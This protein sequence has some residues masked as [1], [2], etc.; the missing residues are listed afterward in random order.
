MSTFG[1]VSKIHRKCGNFHNRGNS[2]LNLTSE[3]TTIG[4][5]IVSKCTPSISKV[6]AKSVLG[7]SFQDPLK[8]H[9]KQ[10]NFHN[11]GGSQ[12][13]LTSEVTTIGAHIV[14]KF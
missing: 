8:T 3:M 10:A 5:H 11:R 7:S 6:T 2:L 1:R 9:K 12:L 4:A 13:K 14:P